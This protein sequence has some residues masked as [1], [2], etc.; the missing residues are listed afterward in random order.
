MADFLLGPNAQMQPGMCT[1]CDHTTG[2]SLIGPRC[3]QTDLAPVVLMGVACMAAHVWQF[4]K[5]GLRLACT[6]LEG[7]TSAAEWCPE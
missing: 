1:Y 7:S 6:L 5:Y 4:R 3:V 2:V